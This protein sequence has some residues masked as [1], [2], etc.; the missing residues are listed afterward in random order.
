MSI[1][2]VWI[3][4]NEYVENHLEELKTAHFLGLHV[5][6]TCLIMLHIL[7]L[8]KTLFYG[9]HGLYCDIASILGYSAPNNIG[10]TLANVTYLTLWKKN[11]FVSLS[12]AFIFTR[13]FRLNF[14]PCFYTG[15]AAVGASRELFGIVY[16]PLM[17]YLLF[18][19]IGVLKGTLLIEY[20]FL[21]M[22]KILIVQLKTMIMHKCQNIITVRDLAGEV[23][24]SEGKTCTSKKY[25]YTQITSLDFGVAKGGD[26]I[27]YMQIQDFS[28][29]KL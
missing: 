23:G 10:T 24:R 11:N 14:E 15:H 17:T 8:M 7:N 12:L 22:D 21:I 4:E 28:D 25:I 13:I 18:I 27:F 1:I 16:T 2:K 3:I 20:S 26:C 6:G 19:I 5:F 9:E 29:T